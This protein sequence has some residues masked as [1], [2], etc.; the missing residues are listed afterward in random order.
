VGYFDRKLTFC[1]L[2]RSVRIPRRF[3]EEL[4]RENTIPAPR[5]IDERYLLRTRPHGL[6]AITGTM[7]EKL[8]VPESLL[9]S[10]Q[11]R[12]VSHCEATQLVR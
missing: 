11:I 9:A 10:A 2:G 4:I 1:K 7:F 12:S 3:I 8:R 6:K 5:C